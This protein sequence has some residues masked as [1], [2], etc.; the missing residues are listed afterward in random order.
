M[1]TSLLLAALIATAGLAG[2]GKSEDP[3]P[4]CK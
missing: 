1:K 3:A 4:A 2:Y